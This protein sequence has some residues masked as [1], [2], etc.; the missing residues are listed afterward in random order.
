[1]PNL[2]PRCQDCGLVFEDPQLWVDPPKYCFVCET[3]IR[4]KAGNKKKKRLE[5]DEELENY[6]Q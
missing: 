4:R 3:R 2:A 1:M 6:L 5:N